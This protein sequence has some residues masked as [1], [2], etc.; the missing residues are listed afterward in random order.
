MS[1]SPLI[2]Y[3]INDFTQLSRLGLEDRLRTLFYQ[4]N[5]N[6]DDF[7]SNHPENLLLAG[8]ALLAALLA[9]AGDEKVRQIFWS[10]VTDRKAVIKLGRPIDFTLTS[11]EAASVDGYFSLPNSQLATDDITIPQGTR[12]LSN[13][14][15]YTTEAETSIA[16]GGNA[17]SSISAGNYE[18]FTDTFVSDG[19]A[20]IELKLS[21]SNV[22]PDSITVNCV[23]GA[24]TNTDLS[25]NQ[26]KSFL[27]MTPDVKGF[28]FYT[29]NN[30]NTYIQFGNGIYGAVPPQ[31]AIEISYNAGGGREGAVGANAAWQ[32]LDTI[33]D[34]SGNAV[35]LFFTNPAASTGGDDEM[36]VYEARTRGPR[37]R[38]LIKACTNEDQYETVA[39]SISG[40][41]RAAAV[42]S[43][44]DPSVNEDNAKLYLVAYGT[45][46]SD[47]GYYPPAA[48]TA[49]QIA[50]VEAAIA[51]TGAHPGIMD[52]T[53][54]VLAAN[55]TTININVR[56]H[57]S[58]NYTGAQV[59][60]NIYQAL[61][62]FFAVADA[63]KVRNEKVDFGYKLLG[64]DGTPD[65]KL[66]WSAI[67][68]EIYDSAGVREIPP[69]QTDLIINSV[70]TSYTLLPVYFPLLGSITI[71]DMDNG[72][73]E[74]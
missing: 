48:P 37:Y 52:F 30:Q 39:T 45:A 38:R 23:D 20:N 63:N 62:K 2:A 13:Q 33:T 66:I 31:G 35:T 68:N 50:A 54:T 59:K 27:D 7:S 51:Q 14:L 1:T 25:G 26:Y 70:R 58:A 53:T 19:I 42:T 74:L 16:S 73:V 10:T 5:P 64:A 43:N 15:I 34:D 49:S 11:R 4:L 40:I 47:S 8:T 46:Y 9:G 67:H 22:L 12:I 29:D 65:Y 71:Y 3:N 55:F 28:M 56:I 61:Q 36:S 18:E 72:G 69:S 21:Q 24:Y 17:S 57:K 41:A 6:W 44:W 32:V 60:A